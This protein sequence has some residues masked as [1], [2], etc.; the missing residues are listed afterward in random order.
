MNIVIEG[1]LENFCKDF[2]YNNIE[3]ETKFEH[4]V[5]YTVVSNEYD[6]TQFDIANIHTDKA[7][8][9]I[10]GIAI[11]INNRLCFS[12]E[13]IKT[14]IEFNNKLEVDFI[15]IQSKITD[16]FDGSEIDAFCRWVKTFFKFGTEFKGQKIKN[17]IDMAKYIYNI[18]N[19]KYLKKGLPNIKLYYV[20]NGIWKDDINLISI[21]EENKKE[22]RNLSL[23]QIINIIP[24]DANKLQQLFMRINTATEAH[25]EFSNNVILPTIERV[26]VAYSGFLPFPEFIKLIVDENNKLKSVF[27]DN[28]RGFLG[29]EDN[30]VN[31][32]MEKTLNEKLFDQF[33]ILNN[34]VTIVAEEI[35]GPGTNKTLKNYQIVNGCQ[36]SNVLYHCKDIDGIDK[37]MVPVK[38]IGTT[39]PEI[40]INVTKSTNNQTKVSIEQLESLTNFQKELEEHYKAFFSNYDQEDRLFYERRKNQYKEQVINPLSIIDIEN[41]I[42]DFVAMFI[43]KPYIV[44]GY[45]SK[46]LKSLG[47]EI[48]NNEH[49]KLPYICSAL[50]YRKLIRLFNDRTID[51]RL[52][53]FRYHMVMLL[54]YFVTKQFPPRLESKKIDEYCNTIIETLRNNVKC[55]KVYLEIQNFLFS[56]DQEIKISGR[57]SSEKKMNTDI[58]LERMRNSLFDKNPT[59][60]DF[61]N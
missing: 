29:I 50:A 23:F 61:I 60:L 25:I 18:N 5:N 35:I 7:I 28:I 10:D 38:I 56:I 9:G 53:R 27:E 58:I 4:F 37:V 24:C 40:R 41:Q 36:T 16:N 3:K 20:C 55:R 45:Y 49:R 42:K 33:C 43:E 14:S 8:Q 22:L 1:Y 11:I 48:F 46:L 17:F 19:N 31:E 2:N 32:A 52:W 30:P 44:S 21:I 39:D 6:S 15:F 59:L 57:K 51:D 12:K 26:D 54:K 47:S 13:E 34:G